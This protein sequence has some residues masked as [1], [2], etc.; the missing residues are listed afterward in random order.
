M[1]V[2]KTDPAEQQ[3][4]EAIIADAGPPSSIRAGSPLPGP[5]DETSNSDDI[6]YLQGPRL[7]GITAVFVACIFFC[8]DGCQ[9]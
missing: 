7:W 2:E 8:M 1:D 4:K 6:I 3:S 5:D 9:L